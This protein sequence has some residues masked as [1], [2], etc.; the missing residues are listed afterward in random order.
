VRYEVQINGRTRRVAVSRSGGGFAVT[1]DG[2]TVHV[3]AARV[4]AQTLS[5]VIDG[6][7][8]E[9]TVAPDPASGQLAVRVGATPVAV[10]LNGLNGRHFRKRD[11]GAHGGTGPQRV[12][13][14]M[15]G[16]IVR[17][18]VQAGVAVA[19]RQPL[20]VVEAMKMENELRSSRAGTVS[21]IHAREGQS[22][23][24]GALL[25]VIQ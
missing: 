13:A 20:V 2:R 4:D 25:V 21:E 6:E 16:K 7:V 8:Y 1:I 12:V 9:V 11:E 3:D 23:E 17:I 14:P 10:G 15:P 19:A 5:L 18:L 22:V 24:A